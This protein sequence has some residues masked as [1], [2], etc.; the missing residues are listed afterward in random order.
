MEMGQGEGPTGNDSVGSNGPQH[1]LLLGVSCL[2]LSLQVLLH[3]L[4]RGR[5]HTNLSH[6]QG[7]QTQDV[8]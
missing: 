8:P 5:A 6:S 4:P 1:Q 3:L 2:A 7:C